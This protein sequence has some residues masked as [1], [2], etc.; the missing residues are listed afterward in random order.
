[1]KFP[2]KTKFILLLLVTCIAFYSCDPKRIYDKFKDIKN[3][4]WDRTETIKF[5]VTIDDTLSY[6]NIFIN[7]R[8]SGSYKF[9]NLYLFLNT[10]YPNRKIS[11]DTVDCL[12]A[13]NKG[14]WLGKG[15]GDLK[16]CK[17]LLKKGVRFHKKGIYTFEFEQA[18]RVEKLEGIK[19]IGI[20]IEKME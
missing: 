2:K 8:N 16:D 12:L 5:E 14:K 15:L 4:T 1:M 10:V 6:N 19:S 20:R 9:S 11:L 18:M 3:G 7:I 17:Y 13:D